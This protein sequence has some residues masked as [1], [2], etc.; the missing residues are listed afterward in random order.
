VLFRDRR[1]ISEYLSFVDFHSLNGSD[2]VISETLN[3]VK[4]AIF[5]KI[6]RIHPLGQL[7]SSK[8]PL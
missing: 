3:H 8:N 5:K 1:R 6:S 4:Y 7:K 2:K